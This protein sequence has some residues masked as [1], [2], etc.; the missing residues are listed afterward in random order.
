MLYNIVFGFIPT[1]KN[2]V[3]MLI[4]S[5]DG[6]ID[7]VLTPVPIGKSHNYDNQR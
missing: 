6:A 3:L 5:V 2:T 4:A 1:Q 7:S